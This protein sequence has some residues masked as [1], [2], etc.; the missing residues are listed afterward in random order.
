MQ[1]ELHVTQYQ[2][3]QIKTPH[4]NF[5]LRPP[6]HSVQPIF[7]GENGHHCAQPISYRNRQEGDFGELEQSLRY[8]KDFLLLLF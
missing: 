4:Q 8:F 1:Y 5:V 3:R 6:H 7:L 2:Q